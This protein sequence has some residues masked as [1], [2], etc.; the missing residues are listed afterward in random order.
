MGGLPMGRLQ[1]CHAHRRWCG[2]G[3]PV[4]FVAGILSQGLPFEAFYR[5]PRARPMQLPHH[6]LLLLDGHNRPGSHVQEADPTDSEGGR[7]E[8]KNLKMC[9]LY[10]STSRKNVGSW[11]SNSKSLHKASRLIGL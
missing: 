3:R 5:V 4:P 11:W 6:R 7:L 9:G 1:L 8:I 2:W 10:A